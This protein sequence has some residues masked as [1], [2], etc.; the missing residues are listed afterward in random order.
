MNKI[1]SRTEM[2][3]LNALAKDVNSFVKSKGWHE[4]ESWKHA[5]ANFTANAHSEISEMWEYFRDGMKLETKYEL[6]GKPYGIPTEIADTIIRL[7]DFCGQ[8][9]V[10]IEKAI[11]EKMKYNEKRPYRHGGKVA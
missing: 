7:L 6:D 2:R 8:W 1:K 3:S 11:V 5:V 10:N 9:D 4:E